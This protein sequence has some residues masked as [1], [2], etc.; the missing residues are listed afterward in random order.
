MILDPTYEG[1]KAYLVV[2]EKW[3]G[4]ELTHGIIEEVCEDGII[5]S[6]SE[7]FAKNYGLM[8]RFPT[9]KIVKIPFKG[10]NRLARVVLDNERPV[11]EDI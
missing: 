7:G 8:I 5:F 3:S 10:E 2:G 4:R 11:H 1:K 9:Q 6:I